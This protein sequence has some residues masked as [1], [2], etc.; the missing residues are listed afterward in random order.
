M[1]SECPY[2]GGSEFSI[3]DIFA[4]CRFRGKVRVC[5][6]HYACAIRNPKRRKESLCQPV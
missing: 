4:E 3:G 5:K 1:C 2:C 6:A